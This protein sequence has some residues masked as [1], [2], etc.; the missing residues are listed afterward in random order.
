MVKV[1]VE[2][3]EQAL[4]ASESRNGFN[5]SISFEGEKNNHFG[6]ETPGTNRNTY[7]KAT[8]S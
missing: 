1:N 7:G 3:T 5:I 4:E 2:I 6:L 8:N